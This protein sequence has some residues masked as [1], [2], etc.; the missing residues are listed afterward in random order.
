MIPQLQAATFLRPMGSGR[1][2]PCLM[3]CED[4]DDHQEEVVVKLRAGIESMEMGSTAEII[5]ALFAN[6]LDLPI[7]F[8]VV[9][10][11]DPDFHKAVKDPEFARR[12]RESVGLNFGSTKLPPGFT[13]WPRTKSLPLLLRQLGA[14]ILLFDTIIQNPDRRKEN[15]NVLWQGD[16]LFVYDHEMS[17]TFF[18]PQLG[19]QP[20]WT[21]QGLEFLTNHVFYDQLKGTELELE[22][23]VGAFEAISD[24]GFAEYVEAVPDEWKT[25]QDWASQM[26]AYLREARQNLAEIVMAVRR[27]LR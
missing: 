1:T 16:E 17:L 2:N 8:P 9:V 14:E 23:V 4:D 3:V 19:W 24:E 18:L 20:P 22:R 21:G 27:L 12:L 11:I 6:D 5:A 15:P 13:T 25:S 26:V 7:P 10:H